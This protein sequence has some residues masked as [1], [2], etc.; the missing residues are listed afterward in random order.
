MWPP[1]G[2]SL[3]FDF[4]FFDVDFDLPDLDMAFLAAT[5]TTVVATKQNTDDDPIASIRRESDTETPLDLR[6]P[7]RHFLKGAQSVDAMMDGVKS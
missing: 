7:P 3:R 6:S 1:F 2:R 4:D 5:K